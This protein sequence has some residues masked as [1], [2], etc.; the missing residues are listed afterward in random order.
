MELE[1]ARKEHA[2]EI[3]DFEGALT[4]EQIRSARLSNDLA[5]ANDRIADL[6]R[7]KDLV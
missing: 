4:E 6:T 3:E 1:N 2:S 5:K 7:A